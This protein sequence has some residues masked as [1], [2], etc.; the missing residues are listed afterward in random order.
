M[1]K[2]WGPSIWYFFHSLAEK[3]SDE[4]YLIL[5]KEVCNI[6][7]HV[8]FHLPCIECTKHAKEYI[9]KH[10]LN[11]NILNTKEKLKEYLFT[12]HNAVNSR[13][14]KPQFTD[15]DKYKTAKMHPI[16]QNFKIYYFKYNEPTRGFIDTMARERIIR[17]TDSFFI[18]NHKYFI[19]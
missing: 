15:Y 7:S 18:S 17:M 8:C 19:N 4:G 5:K 1:T 6:I 13:L 11:P 16:Y 12:F 2:N 3:I 9:G 10:G 14:G